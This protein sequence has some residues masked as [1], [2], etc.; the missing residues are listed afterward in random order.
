VSSAVVWIK[1][2]FGDGP[3][4]GLEA[5]VVRPDEPEKR[6]W[7]VTSREVDGGKSVFAYGMTGRR[8]EDGTELLGLVAAVGRKGGSGERA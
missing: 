3:V 2:E 5:F 1:V 8:R 6:T 4:D 7:L